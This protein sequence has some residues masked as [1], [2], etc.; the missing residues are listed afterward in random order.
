[1]V[2]EEEMAKRYRT[3]AEEDF[4]TIVTVIHHAKSVPL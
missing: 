2:D 1:M 4:M 3:V